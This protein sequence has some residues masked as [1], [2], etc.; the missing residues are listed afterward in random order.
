M[1]YGWEIADEVQRFV[2]NSADVKFVEAE[3]YEAVKAECAILREANDNCI[4][5][6]LHESRM[7]AIEEENAALK[8]DYGTCDAERD[9]LK[10]EVER[11]K[12]KWEQEQDLLG[13]C[14]FNHA[15]KLTKCQE[16]REQVEF[17]QSV[18]RERES[19]NALHLRKLKQLEDETDKLRAEVERLKTCD[20]T[21]AVILAKLNKRTQRN[22]ELREHGKALYD[23]LKSE[24]CCT[25]ETECV[26]GIIKPI[27]CDA[28]EALALHGKFFV[29][30][31]GE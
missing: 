2:G 30:G 9:T 6:G 16:L 21:L 13:E 26:G 5:R 1:K 10:A 8:S 15:Q 28:C 20:E 14:L 29:E 19:M 12:S 31:G 22:A 18:V 3:A 11:L 24:C 4:S 7:Q 23:A 25:G 17:E 27:L